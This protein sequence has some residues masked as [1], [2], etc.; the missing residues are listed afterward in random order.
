MSSDSTKPTEIC[1]HYA[2]L[3][4][5][6]FPGNVP[7]NLAILC[8]YGETNDIF[9]P[10]GVVQLSSRN[11]TSTVHTFLLKRLRQLLGFYQPFNQFSKIH[12]YW[13]QDVFDEY[14]PVKYYIYIIYV[15]FRDFI[16][17]FRNIGGHRLLFLILISKKDYL[18][19]N[20]L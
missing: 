20:I 16:E 13:E 6:I 15:G 17:K 14:E 8:H 5:R 12:L 4:I 10:G 9:F 7:A 1:P 3:I 2:Y 11:K 19:W 18:I